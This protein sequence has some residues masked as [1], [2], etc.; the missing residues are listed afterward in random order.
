LLAALEKISQHGPAGNTHRDRFDV[1]KV[2][3]GDILF[4]YARAMSKITKLAV[5]APDDDESSRNTTPGPS[6]ER[7]AT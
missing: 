2:E 5:E 3:G 6:K 7:R 4:A 1:E